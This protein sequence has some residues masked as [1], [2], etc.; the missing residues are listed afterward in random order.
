MSTEAK[1]GVFVLVSL[2][3]LGSAAYFVH[4]TQTVRGQVP[5]KTYL[6]YAGGLAPGALVLFG[7]IK[8][9]Q[10]TTVAPSPA[11][12]TQI[13]ILFEV[14]SGTP[15]N[16][17]STARV[18]TVSMMSGPALS[19]TT[20]SNEARRLRAGETV[21]SEE[22]VSLEEVTL[23]LATVAESAN[24]LINELGKEIPGLIGE[25]E[26]LLANLNTI[27]GERNQKQIEQILAEINALLSRESPKVAQITDQVSLLTKHADEVVLSFQPVPDN[28][29]R[30]ITNANNTIDAIREPLTKSLAEL[31]R[32]IV[33]ARALVASMQRVVDTNEEDIDE[34]IR[35]LR[36]TSENVRALTESLKQ[37]PWSLVRTKQ[38]ADRRVPR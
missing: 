15:V 21:P 28:I 38:P 6:R 25:A 8:V 13:E 19:I 2:L 16:Q 36:T 3:V 18:G 20:G 26:T 7:G 32:T 10:V 30:T 14:K 23:R 17:K 33:E 27:T 1:V 37:R 34:M 4:T 11:D 24:T 29:D 9:G 5:Y 31:E 35:N 12:P 22:A